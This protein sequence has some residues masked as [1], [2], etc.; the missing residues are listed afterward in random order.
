[1][2]NFLQKMPDKLKAFLDTHQIYG[3]NMCFYSDINEKAEF[4]NVYFIVANGLFYKIKLEDNYIEEFKGELIEGIYTDA[5][6]T[7][8]KLYLKYDGKKVFLTYY[9]KAFASYISSI[10]RYLIKAIKN[11]LEDKDYQDYDKNSFKVKLCKKCNRPLPSHSDTCRYCGGNKNALV[12]L[13][14][15]IGNYKLSFT[16]IVVFLLFISAIGMILPIMTGRILYN[17]V[18]DE[19][20]RFFGYILGFVCVYLGLKI[21][22]VIFNIVYGRLIAITSAALCYDIK[23]DVFKSMQKLSLSFFTDKDTGTLMNRVIWDSNQVFYYLIDQIPFCFT[24]FL[25]L[26]GMITYLMVLSPLLTSLILIPL[27]LLFLAY[28]KNNSVFRYHWNQQHIKMNKVSSQISDTLEGFRIVK[29]FSGQEKEVRKFNKVSKDLVEVQNKRQRFLAF[30]YPFFGA[31]PAIM[32]FVVWGVGGYLTIT[33]KINYGIFMTFTASLSLIYAPF[34]FFNNF[35]FN[36][37]PW[38]LNSA[39]R[40]FEIIDAKPTIIEKEE[41]LPLNDI[42]GDIEF[43]NVTFSYD[44]NNQILNNIDFK[45]KANT[46]FGIVGK[47][48][49]GKSTLVH[50][51]TRLYDVNDGEILIDNKNIKDLSLKDLHANVAL[52]S[53]DVYMFKGSIKDNIAYAKENASLQEIIEAAKKAHAH[54]FIMEL[55]DGY[56]TR[57]GEGS[58]SLSGGEKQRISIARAILLDPKIII[59]DEATAALDTKTER[60]IQESIYKLSKGRTVILI[61]HRLSTL[62]DADELVVIEDGKV[63]EHGSMEQLLKN[64]K[65]FAELYKIQQEGLKYIRVGD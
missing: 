26:V 45:I 32:G 33:N 54:E 1:M 38:T 64:E 22:D 56:E 17:E 57:I 24:H 36:H 16:L 10:E 4:A 21:L 7:N 43:K 65:Q 14:K 31:F 63:V 19:K 61:A 44:G 8:G 9:S 3:V 60:M 58:V 18:L 42:K 28:Y 20:G 50:L 13:L 25:K 52:I 48:G 53:Q 46:T 2:K 40:I 12:R 30:I 39:K 55:S 34:N 23:N 59:F 29:V 41:K 47:T 11:E 49:A 62:K 27:P 6:L 37:T 15:Y 35:I 5:L 51:L